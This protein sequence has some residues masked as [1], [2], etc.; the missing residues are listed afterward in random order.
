MRDANSNGGNLFSLM[1]LVSFYDFARF[2]QNDDL[3]KSINF[4]Q[5]KT[6]EI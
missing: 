5:K 1:A 2:N 4:A 3:Q 6:N